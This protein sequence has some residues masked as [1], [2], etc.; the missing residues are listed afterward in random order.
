MSVCRAHQQHPELDDEF[1]LRSTCGLGGPD[2]TVVHVA[3]TVFADMG[4]SLLLVAN[5]LRLL[6]SET[7]RAEWSYSPALSQ[8]RLD[9]SP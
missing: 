6:R 8:L 4:A 5:G 7:S 9:L 2:F 1:F 3:A